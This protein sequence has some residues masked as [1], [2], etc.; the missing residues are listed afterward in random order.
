[1]AELL[2]KVLSSLGMS[3]N[4][5]EESEKINPA[6][7]GYNLVS[8]RGV[9]QN[10]NFSEEKFN[11]LIQN[12]QTRDDDVYICTYVKAGTTWTQQIITML[13]NGGNQGGKTLY[14]QCPWLE[15]ATS[16]FLGPREAPGHTIESITAM[17]GPRYFKTHANF[18]DLPRG[19]APGLKVIYVA[20][21]PKD[22]VVSLFHHA[23]NKPEFGYTGDFKTFVELFMA[24]ACE[25]GSWFT[26]VLEWWEESKTNP[27]VL[28]LKYEDMIAD[29]TA[30][31]SKIAEFCSLDSS[32]EVISKTV[33][34]SSMKSMKANQ[35][36]N[37]LAAFNHLRKG[38]SGGWKD[39]FTVALS[40]VFD[41]VYA[42]KMEGSGLT[43]DFGD[44]VQ[45]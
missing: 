5:A 41:L 17:E 18:N 22:T 39:Y 12:F 35:Q 31:I 20:R 13:L 21:N 15:A 27:N 19:S 4:P 3:D 16:D 29:P 28:F 8:I 36:A 44:G 24:G 45:F 33:E 37:A 11:E 42:T 9:Y 38:G 43:F 6:D 1:M 25:N 14:E 26:H 30:S 7:Y 34:N 23:K 10:P 2:S 40:E 32:P